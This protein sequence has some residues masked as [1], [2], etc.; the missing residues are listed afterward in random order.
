MDVVQT[1]GRMAGLG[2][3]A[4]AVPGVGAPQP[5]S[6]IVGTWRVVH[7]DNIE[8]GKVYHRF[9]E[10]P[11]G[12]FVY[13]ADGHVAI[14]AS[15]PAN[16]ICVAPA[17]KYDQGRRDETNTPACTSKQMQALIDGTIA[18]WGTYS[19]DQAEGVV[20]HYVKSDLA[21][22]Y[23]GTEQRRPFK[24]EG[25]RLEIGDGKTWIRVLERVK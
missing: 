23:T 10:K 17:T 14:Q 6:A 1:I 20:I 25:D 4:L 19:V 3:L 24:L 15:N 22:G 2:L 18:Y 11:L 21:N 8:N 7:F 13:T 9:G 16:P 12:L 5:A